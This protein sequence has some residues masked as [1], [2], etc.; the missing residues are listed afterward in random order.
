MGASEAIIVVF[1]LGIFVL[2]TF[3]GLYRSLTAGDKGWAA[4][5]GV[6][7]VVGLGWLFGWIYLLGPGRKRSASPTP[8]AP[9]D[10]SR[11]MPPA[12]WHS[13][14]EG[15]HRLRYFDGQLWTEETAD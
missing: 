7:W 4:A 10:P 2:P 15:T 9:N 12:G 5:I 6:T 1:I 14:P 11:A 3:F 8:P 13:D